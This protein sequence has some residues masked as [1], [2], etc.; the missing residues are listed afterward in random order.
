MEVRAERDDDRPAIRSVIAS[1][2][3]QAAHAA[4]NEAQIVEALRDAGALTLSLVAEADGEIVGHVAF[5]PV[6]IAARKGRYLGLGPVAVLPALQSGGIG[7]AL[8]REGLR[9][10]CADGAAG[11]VVLGNPGYYRRFGFSSDPALTFAGQPSPYFQ[12]LVWHGDPPSGDVA[13]HPAFGA[14]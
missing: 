11:C 13:Y 1:A 5:S 4:G 10:I 7:A 12:R 9:R 6:R 3:A 8:I 2:F 14:G